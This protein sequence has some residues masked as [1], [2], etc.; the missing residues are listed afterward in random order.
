MFLQYHI[1]FIYYL[2]VKKDGLSSLG[3]KLGYGKFEL[4]T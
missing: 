3:K 2:K 1:L 4:R